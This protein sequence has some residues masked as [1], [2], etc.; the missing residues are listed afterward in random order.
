MELEAQIVISTKLTVT[1]LVP[2]SQNSFLLHV[3]EFGCKS[4]A[5]RKQID[6]KMHAD[7]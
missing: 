5:R 3:Q 1:D 7:L 4:T 2:A 6:R